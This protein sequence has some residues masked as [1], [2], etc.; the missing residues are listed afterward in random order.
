MKIVF[1]FVVNRPL[2]IVLLYTVVVVVLVYTK[3]KLSNNNYPNT[4]TI[5]N[6]NNGNDFF[7]LNNQLRKQKFKQP[8][9]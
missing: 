2:N 1:A 9:M 8:L 5:H 3:M 6:V 4:V 7:L